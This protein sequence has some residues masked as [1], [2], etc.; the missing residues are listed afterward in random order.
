SILIGLLPGAPHDIQVTRVELEFAPPPAKHLN[1]R[2]AFDAWIEYR[3]GDA[4][5]FIG[6]E[7]KLTEPF[8]PHKYDFTERYS[9]WSATPGWWWEKGAE[10]HF[11]K[12]QFNQL[13]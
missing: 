4:S 7:T 3:R 6:I 1:D 2:T 5:G 8:S 12:P 9:R 11:H 10:Q 13:W